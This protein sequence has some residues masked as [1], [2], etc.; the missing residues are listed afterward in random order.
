MNK[1]KAVSIIDW[2]SMALITFLVIYT[3]V[4]ET[5][6]Y[7]NFYINIILAFIIVVTR[8][9]FRQRKLTI[10][11]EL[12]KLL[13]ITIISLLV[14]STLLLIKGMPITYKGFVPCVI[15]CLLYS[16][17][18][19]DIHDEGSAK[20]KMSLV[21]T[22]ILVLSYV[23]IRGIIML[24]VYPLA[25]RQIAGFLSEAE[26][27]FYLNQGVVNF[28]HVYAIAFMTYP[29]LKFLQVTN[30]K[31]LRA[32]CFVFLVVDYIVIV[33]SAY[34]M[35]FLLAFFSTV[36]FLFEIIKSRRL[37]VFVGIISG[38]VVFL[39]FINGSQL[40][41]EFLINAGLTTQAS[42]VKQIL[43]FESG[44]DLYSINRY[45]LYRISI[46][47]F[48][49][50]PLFGTD[51][52]G[53]HSQFFDALSIFGVFSTFYFIIIL[54]QYS[55]WKKRMNTYS[56]R[57]VYILFGLFVVLNTF[58]TSAQSTAWFLMVPITLGLADNTFKEA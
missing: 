12:G 41:Y 46:D 55:K 51:N 18:F 13:G 56:A 34:S 40:L 1:N 44:G 3:C 11:V 7:Y 9:V 30:S 47:N 36:L 6:K 14:L 19:L 54:G 15:Q 28:G 29:V 43:S 8:Y 53:Q 45:R 16:V 25:S 17:I 48:F 2:L 57:V 22:F 35:A 5:Y 37:K 33:K 38:I 52:C 42:K 31:I 26:S 21:V 24:D 10:S 39:T 20:F 27:A 50:H 23:A 4:P 49:Q 58:Y 32:I